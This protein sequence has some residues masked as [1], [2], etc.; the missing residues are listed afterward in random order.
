MV[1]VDEH[2]GVETDWIVL[3]ALNNNDSFLDSFGIEHIRKDVKRFINKSIV[4]VNI[5]RIQACNMWIFLYWIYWF[6][7]CRQ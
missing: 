7:A 1:N 5:S 4:V 6:I 3:H 2:S